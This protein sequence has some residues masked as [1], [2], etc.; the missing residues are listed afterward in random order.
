MQND[1]AVRIF[2]KS[3]SQYKSDRMVHEIIECNGRTGYLTNKLDH[4]TFDN[5]QEYLDKLNSY[6]RL[7]AQELRLKNLKPTFY[8]YT[9]KP[10][11]RFFNYFVMRLGFLD[12]KDGYT[13]AKLHAI[14]VANRYKYLDEIY[15]KENQNLG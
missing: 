13:I 2:K 11:Y 4:F 8:H 12:G 5:E 14:S 1:K 6:S 10:A 9:I 7:R 3:K 15:R